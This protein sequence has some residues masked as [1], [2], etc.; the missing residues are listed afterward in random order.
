MTQPII[1]ISAL[2][3]QFGDQTVLRGI[4]LDVQPGDRIAILG[5]SGSG[6]STFLRCLNFMEHPSQG[7][8]ELQG[9]P[10]GSVMG[11]GKVN[12][13]Q[14]QLCSVRQ[15]VGMVF[16]QFNLFGHMTVLANVM[17]GL[18]TVLGLPTS[19]ARDRAMV[20]LAKVGMADKATASGS[21]AGRAHILVGSR[22]GVRGAACHPQPSR[23]RPDHAAGHA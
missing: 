15:V 4:D 17:E 11:T 8:I 13:A 16:Q 21:A 20:Q 22:V 6:K 12:Y 3:K 18:V 14:A 9:Q 10:I 5:A 7:R 23:G 19:M 2:Q 1:R